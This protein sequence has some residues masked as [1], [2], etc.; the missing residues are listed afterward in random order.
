MAINKFKDEIYKS[1]IQVI[2]INPEGKILESE[3]TIFSFALNELIT[4]YHPF[5][6]G[7]ASLFKEVSE[8]IHFPCVNLEI[9]SKNIIADVDLI[10]EKNKIFLLIFDFTNHYQE[11]HPLVQEKTKPPFKKLNFHTKE[12]SL[13]PKKILR[14]SF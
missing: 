13:L 4:D 12:I 14:I 9:A 3:N 10:H 11:S 6:E 8:K 7:I 1:K 2:Q 5:F